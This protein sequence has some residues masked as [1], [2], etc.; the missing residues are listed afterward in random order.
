MY[1]TE[2]IFA[3]GDSNITFAELVAGTPENHAMAQSLA[4]VSSKSFFGDKV[5]E[6]KK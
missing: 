1:S 6:Y 2:I 4:R 5:E 3:R